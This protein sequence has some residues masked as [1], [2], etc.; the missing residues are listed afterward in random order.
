M[1][2]ADAMDRNVPSVAPGECIAAV[3]ERVR[4]FRDDGQRPAPGRG[5]GS[6]GERV[7]CARQRYTSGTGTTS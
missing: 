2:D 3:G 5:A 7:N 6:I 1:D 4:M